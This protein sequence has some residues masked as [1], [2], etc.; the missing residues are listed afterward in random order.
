MPN[1]TIYPNKWFPPAEATEHMRT[2]FG[3]LTAGAM[4]TGKGLDRQSVPEMQ[5]QLQAQTSIASHWLRRTEESK[6]RA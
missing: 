3:Q 4:K 5:H 6:A 1:R 2:P